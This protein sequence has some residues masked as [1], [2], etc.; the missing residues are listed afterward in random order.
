M[1]QQRKGLA[2]RTQETLFILKNGGGRNE[3]GCWLS[4]GRDGAQRGKGQFIFRMYH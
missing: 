4:Q 2:K 1:S 3:R